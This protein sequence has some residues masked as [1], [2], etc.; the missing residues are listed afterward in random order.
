MGCFLKD[1][2]DL[3]LFEDELDAGR[4]VAMVNPIQ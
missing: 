4:L 2:S 3:R 1:E